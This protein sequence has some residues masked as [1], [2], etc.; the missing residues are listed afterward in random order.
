M[1]GQGV[2][3]GCGGQ[4]SLGCHVVPQQ[5]LLWHSFDSAEIPGFSQGF[6]ALKASQ[7]SPSAGSGEFTIAG[8]GDGWKVKPN[9]A[10]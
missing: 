1:S 4:M 7:P 10:G 8:W 9:S 6:E 2:S 3:P 5:G